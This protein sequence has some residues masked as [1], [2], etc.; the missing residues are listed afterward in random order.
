MWTAGT[1]LDAVDEIPARKLDTSGKA[2]AAEIDSAVKASIEVQNE[3]FEEAKRIAETDV[4]AIE[5]HLL[6]LRKQYGKWIS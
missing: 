1:L 3:K 6:L 4:A 2:T 5:S